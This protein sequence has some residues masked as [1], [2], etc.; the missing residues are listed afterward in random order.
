M[1]SGDYLKE[2]EEKAIKA[3]KEVLSKRFGLVDLRL[4]GSK[5]RAKA[6]LNRM[7]M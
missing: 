7:S 4:F 5:T 6:I 1:G 2:N 3:L